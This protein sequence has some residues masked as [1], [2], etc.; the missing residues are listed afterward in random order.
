MFSSLRGKLA[1]SQRP[2]RCLS[3]SKVTLLFQFVEAQHCWVLGDSKSSSGL[4]EYQVPS[5]LFEVSEVSGTPEPIW[6]GTEA[7][8]RQLSISRHS[9]LSFFE[10]H[11]SFQL[12]M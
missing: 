10:A 2:S 9:L 7:L 11:A 12:A 1:E 4:I 5:L 6:T 3:H 8:A